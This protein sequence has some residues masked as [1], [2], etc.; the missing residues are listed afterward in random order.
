MGVLERRDGHRV[1]LDDDRLQRS[2]LPYE[3]FLDAWERAPAEALQPGKPLRV[4]I[5]MGRVVGLALVV[6][7]PLIQPNEPTTFARRKLTLHNR[8]SRVVKLEGPAPRAQHITILGDW[9]VG[10]ELWEV[11]TAYSGQY[12]YPQPWDFRVIMRNHLSLNA[13]LDYWCKAAFLWRGRDFETKLHNDTWAGLIDDA[14]RVQR[15]DTI[16]RIGYAEV[17]R[18]WREPTSS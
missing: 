15:P 14:A 4:T 1:F 2:G 16:V 3:T 13:V 18:R 10:E 7:A 17:A 9:K 11:R 12:I 5:D 6:K 8:P